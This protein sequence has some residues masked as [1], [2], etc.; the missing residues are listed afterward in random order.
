MLKI[1]QVY[2]YLKENPLTRSE[3]KDKELSE[4]MPLMLNIV[5]KQWFKHRTVP[6]LKGFITRQIKNV[7][8]NDTKV[9][10]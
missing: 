10:V 5:V 6:Y 3:F 7:R 2:N 1:D 4:I 9:C 8:M